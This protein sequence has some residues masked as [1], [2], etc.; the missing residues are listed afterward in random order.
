MLEVWIRCEADRAELAR[1]RRRSAEETEARRVGLARLDLMRRGANDA[2]RQGGAGARVEA[3]LAI[4]EAEGSRLERSPDPGLWEDAA[5]RCEALGQPWETAYAQF[6]QG[7]AILASGGSRQEA[8]PLLR[9]AHEIA[10]KLGARPLVGQIEGLARRGR[11][12]LA[13]VPPHRR[14]RTATTAE[15]VVVTL[16]TREWEVLSNVAAGHTNREIGEQLFIT[17]KTASVHISNVMDK[18]GALSRY[19]AAAIATRLG[20]LDT[21]PGESATR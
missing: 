4:A 8:P 6:R 7:E 2:I 15:G 12:R 21:T 18:L 1:G 10:S 3:A 13:L 14:V 16:T 19:E 17:E 5:R 9:D 11:I 20:L